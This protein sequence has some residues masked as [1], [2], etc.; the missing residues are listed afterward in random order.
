MSQ[1]FVVLRKMWNRV[2]TWILLHAYLSGD[3]CVDKVELPMGWI[4]R[5]KCRGHKV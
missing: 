2:K 1:R 4:R 5:C 3:K